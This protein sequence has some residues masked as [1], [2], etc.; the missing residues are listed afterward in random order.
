[1]KHIR[2]ELNVINDI[3]PG[4]AE[5]SIENELIGYICQN[6]NENRETLPQSI[7]LPNGENFGDFCC[8][9]HAVKAITKHHCGDDGVY[10]SENDPRFKLGLLG[11]LLRAFAENESSKEKSPH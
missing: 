8:V 1:M 3:R 4:V 5:I 11:M 10:I 6:T 2:V 9:E 7:I